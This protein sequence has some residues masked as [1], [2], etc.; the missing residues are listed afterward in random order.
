M[1]TK[2][3]IDAMKR[4]MSIGDWIPLCKQL[5][6]EAMYLI[7]SDSTDEIENA[8]KDSKNKE[9]DPI[10]DVYLGEMDNLDI[11]EFVKCAITD[12][13]AYMYF[14]YGALNEKPDEIKQFEK[15]EKEKAATIKK[16]EEK[17]ADEFAIREKKNKVA[18]ELQKKRGLI[19]HDRFGLGIKN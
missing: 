5:A 4:G 10:L 17:E 12:K 3:K 7:G 9:E 2:D 13:E 16:R 11:C 1:F 15:Y 14:R 19:D 6:K 8:L 18:I